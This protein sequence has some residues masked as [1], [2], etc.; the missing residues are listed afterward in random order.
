MTGMKH[1]DVIK[2]KQVPLVENYPPE[3]MLPKDG[4]YRYLQQP[5]EE[6]NNQCKRVTNRIWSKKTY[7]LSEVMSS[8]GNR[9]I[10]RLKDGIE[11]VFIKEE[12]ML[13][14]EATELPLIMSKNGEEVP[15]SKMNFS[16]AEQGLAWLSHEVPT[17][18]KES[19]R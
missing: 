15:A 17:A 12:L 1:K 2:L 18:L 7:M 4:L 5:G 3:D 9:M 6:H 11:T 10:Y 8:P 13:I 14:P 19:I 16:T